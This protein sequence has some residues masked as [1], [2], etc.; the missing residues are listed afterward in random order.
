MHVFGS[1]NGVAVGCRKADSLLN[2]NFSNFQN[3]RGE[4]SEIPPR[5]PLTDRVTQK[6]QKPAT[7]I[8]F[9]VNNNI[10]PKLTNSSKT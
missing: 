2:L 5:H 1:S 8:E 9:L 7:E 4:G 10:S 3:L 6:R